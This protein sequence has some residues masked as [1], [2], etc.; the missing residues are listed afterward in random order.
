MPN[1]TVGDYCC[2]ENLIATTDIIFDREVIQ[3]PT[4]NKAGV[5]M[6]VFS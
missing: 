3:E 6:K 2:E 1:E 5:D 4:S